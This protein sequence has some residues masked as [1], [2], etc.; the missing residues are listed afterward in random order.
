MWE[1]QTVHVLEPCYCYYI[2]DTPLSHCSGKAVTTQQA[3]RGQAA[4]RRS[5]ALQAAKP[6]LECRFAWLQS[7]KVFIILWCVHCISETFSVDQKCHDVPIVHQIVQVL[8][9][10]RWYTFSV[11][12][13]GPDKTLRTL[14]SELCISAPHW[15]HPWVCTHWGHKP[16]GVHTSRALGPVGSKRSHYNTHWHWILFSILPLVTENKAHFTKMFSW[17]QGPQ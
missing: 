12:E 7:W 13:P 6:G 2:I 1:R 17:C 3:Q 16:P 14:K 15:G 9:F 8:G 5:P 4:H 10:L 11:E